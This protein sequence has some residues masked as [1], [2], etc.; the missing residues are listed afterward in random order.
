MQETI[1][2]ELSK[3]EFWRLVEQTRYHLAMCPCEVC[4]KVRKA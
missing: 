1:S 4:R 2:P 3:E